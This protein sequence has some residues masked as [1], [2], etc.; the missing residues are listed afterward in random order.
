MA[1]GI[2]FAGAGN[3]ASYTPGG[4]LRDPSTDDWSMCGWM[5]ITGDSSTGTNRNCPFYLGDSGYHSAWFGC[6]DT[7]SPWDLTANSADGNEAFDGHSTG[8]APVNNENWFYAI[9]Y[10][11]TGGVMTF[12]WAKSGDTSLQSYTSPQTLWSNFATRINI[13]AAGDGTDA[14]LTGDVTNI[15]C[16]LRTLGSSE[17]YSQMKSASVVNS[18]SLY[19]HWPLLTASDLTGAVNSRV[20][21]VTG[22]ATN[23]TMNVQDIGLKSYRFTGLRIR[24]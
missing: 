1:R 20:F 16:W 4:T 23:G 19:E 9:T 15:M 14:A 6:T 7:N 5:M 3:Y 22:S 12:Y 24:H 18:T 10:N 17:L 11:H 8:S 13:G 2:H 21:T